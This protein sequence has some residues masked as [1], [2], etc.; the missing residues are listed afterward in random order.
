ML[1]ETENLPTTLEYEDFQECLEPSSCTGVQ[2]EEQPRTSLGIQTKCNGAWLSKKEEARRE[3]KVEQSMQ[4]AYEKTSEA[5][6]K[7]CETGI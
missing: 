7:K 2:T 5:V 4:A 1:G 3:Q 6:A